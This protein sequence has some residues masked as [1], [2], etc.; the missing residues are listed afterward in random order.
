MDEALLDSRD[1]WQY[2]VE[3]AIASVCARR[4]DAGPLAMEYRPLQHALA[5]LVDD[6]QQRER[7][8][9]LCRE[10][11]TRGAMKRLLVHEGIC[12]A[13]ARL[14]AR[15]IEVGAIS[16]EPHAIALK[17]IAST[18]LDRFLSVLAA[19]PAGSHWDA[20]ER[21]LPTASHFSTTNRAPACSFQE[22]EPALKCSNT[23]AA[24]S[25]QPTGSA[26]SPAP[27]S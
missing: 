22:R 25:T 27:R 8:E 17:A 21:F 14:R 15:Q 2:A 9:L 19:T 5:I 3:E 16:R 24:Y 1:A 20:G 26:L 7:C 10:I 12:M 11:L 18:G 23:P 13:R 4:I 6:P